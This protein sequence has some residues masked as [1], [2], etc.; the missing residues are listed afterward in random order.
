MAGKIDSET[1]SFIL[2]CLGETNVA[3][4]LGV[5]DL[6]QF[7]LAVRDGKYVTDQQAARFDVAQ[8][9]LYRI[10]EG[11]GPTDALAWFTTANIADLLRENRF[12]EVQEL[13]EAYMMPD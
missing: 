5:T 4:A 3:N 2:Y 10:I 9:Q 13:A 1:L 7:L 11:E 8:T 12:V 6:R